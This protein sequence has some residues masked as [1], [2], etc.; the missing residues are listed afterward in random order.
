MTNKPP[1]Y[2]VPASAMQYDL[3]KAFNA[4]GF[5]RGRKGLKK[6]RIY[7]LSLF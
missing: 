1:R 4:A 5:L 7:K 2:G 6:L 3:L